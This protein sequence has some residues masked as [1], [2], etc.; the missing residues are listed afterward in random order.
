MKAVGL[1][2]EQLVSIPGGRREVD[3]K[4]NK[5]AVRSMLTTCTALALASA[6][7]GS[8]ALTHAPAPQTASSGQT[9]APALSPRLR[10]INVPMRNAGVYHIATQTWTRGRAMQGL[11]GSDVIYDN[12]CAPGVYYGMLAGESIVD[13]GRLPSTTSP[14]S[15]GYS[16]MFSSN[17][18]VAGDADQYT[19]SGFQ[20]AY[21]TSEPGTIDARV[22]F[23]DCY[24]ICSGSTP[25]SSPT[26]SFLLTGLPASAVAGDLSCWTVTIDLSGGGEFVIQSDCDGSYGNGDIAEDR[27]GF[28]FEPLTRPDHGGQGL[29]MAGD[30]QGCSS[31]TS[32][33]YGCGT[34]F[35]DHPTPGACGT[36]GPAGDEAG[37][38][39]GQNTIFDLYDAQGVLIFCQWLTTHCWEPWLGGYLELY[40]TIPRPGVSFCAGDSSGAACPC[41]NSG[42][43]GR[44]CS[45]S[46]GRGA[47][48]S[49]HGDT[50]ITSDTLIFRGLGLLQGQ[51]ALLFQADNQLA[52]GAGLPFGDGLRCAGGNIARLGVQLPGSLDS[53][54]WGPGLATQA[55]V[56]PGQ[57]KTYQCWY[58]D[59]GQGPCG[60]G[61]NLSNGISITWMP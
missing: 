38:G 10:P 39:L 56:T 24:A 53:A 11:L 61:F 25:L 29:V 54:F 12:T 35:S 33:W 7:L 6:S 15:G 52:G 41:G 1:A 4:L 5:F 46:N 59:P 32:C 47:L 2:C 51:A 27:F 44:G 18:S 48:L 49:A 50:S 3:M 20:L 26:A 30:E 14:P 60:S 58:R 42:E 31:P 45:N 19:I 17:K 22:S 13:A 21:C 23:M 16:G 8:S 57:T 43:A 9:P 40:S 55:G 34:S 37:S 36:L 28:I